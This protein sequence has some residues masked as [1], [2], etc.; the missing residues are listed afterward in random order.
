M[1]VKRKL[2]NNAR[3]YRCKRMNGR[4][5]VHVMQYDYEE[6]SFCLDCMIALKKEVLEAIEKSEVLL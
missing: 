6:H 2:I 4:Y 5:R 3:C 1:P